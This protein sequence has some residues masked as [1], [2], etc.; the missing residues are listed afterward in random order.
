MRDGG[1]GFVRFAFRYHLYLCGMQVL[2]ISGTFGG[3]AA[4]V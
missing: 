2:L 4:A 1:R 3:A